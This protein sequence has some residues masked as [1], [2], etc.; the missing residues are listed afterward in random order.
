MTTLVARD[1]RGALEFLRAAYENEEP[2]PFP[3]HVLGVLRGLIPS[4]IVTYREWDDCSGSY[5]HWASGVDIEDVEQIWDRYPAVRSQDPL[6]GVCPRG[7]ARVPTGTAFQFSDFLSQRRFR[8]LELYHDVCRPVGT[9]YVMKLFL[10]LDGRSGG[11]VLE[12]ER[13]DFTPRDRGVLDL[14]APHLVLVRRRKQAEASASEHSD[15]LTAL[16]LR[17]RQVLGLVAGGLT[18]REIAIALV[19]APGTVRKHL[20]NVYRKLSVRSR[21]EAVAV[22]RITRSSGSV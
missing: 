2:A 1:Y 15:A 13:R 6:P 3:T 14:L 18:N 19:V 4:S 17:E 7:D 9:N 21:A 12:S 8:R 20:D 5:A 16:T 11:F 22:T 10:P